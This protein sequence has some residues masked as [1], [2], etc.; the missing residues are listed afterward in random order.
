MGGVSLF[1][2]VETVNSTPEKM[3]LRVEMRQT[4]LKVEKSS[5]FE[6]TSLNGVPTTCRNVIAKSE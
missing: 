5:H 4:C 1:I 3:Y 6:H 2:V